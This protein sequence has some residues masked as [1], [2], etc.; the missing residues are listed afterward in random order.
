MQVPSS[1]VSRT[2]TCTSSDLPK[3]RWCSSH[4]HAIKR[5]MTAV[6]STYSRTAPATV[7][8]LR[9][10]R[11]TRRIIIRRNRPHW[12]LRIDFRV[13]RQLY[14]AQTWSDGGPRA[15]ITYIGVAQGD[16]LLPFLVL[17][18]R[19]RWCFPFAIT[20]C[21]Q[22]F[23]II[24]H[25]IPSFGFRHGRGCRNGLREASLVERGCCVSGT[26]GIGY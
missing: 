15:Q 22:S 5:H 2:T 19:C 1:F 18:Q 7:A 24:Y 12:A 10:A 16:C 26:V 17:R 23:P 14:D 6:Y 13:D 8:Q 25:S 3:R 9:N 11:S 20:L 21:N 4:L